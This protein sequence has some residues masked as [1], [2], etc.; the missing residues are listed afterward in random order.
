M[1]AL[2]C[3]MCFKVL[4]FPN[5]HNRHPIA[6]PWGV[7]CDSNIW[8]TFCHCYRMWYCDKLDRI[9]TALDCIWM[10][11]C[12]IINQ[13]IMNCVFSIHLVNSA[14]DLKINDFSMN[15][16]SRFQWF[17]MISSL[18]QISSSFYEI[19]WFFHDL[20]AAMNFNDFSSAVRTLYIGGYFN[21]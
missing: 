19:H 13:C 12:F 16:S 7:C 10:T 9:I 18:L 6:R 8:F 4:S 21:N 17:S 14:S 2:H 1:T 11:W 3:R 5:H 15:D 20:K